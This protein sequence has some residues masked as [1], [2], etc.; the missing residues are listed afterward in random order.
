MYTFLY[1][2]SFFSSSFF[3]LPLFYFNYFAPLVD[4]LHQSASLTSSLSFLALYFAAI[5]TK[6]INRIFYVLLTLVFVTMSIDS[7][8][9]KA[10]M[11]IVLGF[12]FGLFFILYNAAI[13]SIKRYQK[14]F[15]FLVFGMVLLLISYFNFDYVYDLLLLFFLENDGGQGR[16]FIYNNAFNHGL[17][18]PIVGYGPGAHVP[19]DGEFWDAHSTF[20]TIFLQSGI[21]GL[22]CFLIFFFK[23]FNLSRSHFALVGAFVVILLYALGGD[24]LRR[25]PIWVILLGIT[26]LSIDESKRVR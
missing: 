8:S 10:L 19:L 18:S 17:S 23:I 24:I 25:M 21:L 5:N 16:E 6:F 13:L 9:T 26:Y 15:I 3:G 2:Y 1:L 7:G 20:L 14:I 12:I 11:G 22:A 4:N